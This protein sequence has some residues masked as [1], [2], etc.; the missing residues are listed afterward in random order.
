MEIM[1][2]LIDFFNISTLSQ[3]ASLVELLEFLIKLYL[4]VFVL[5]AIFK[6]LF[7]M[8]KFR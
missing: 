3:S 6:G 7:S 5:L 4:A 1:N 8:T 2:S